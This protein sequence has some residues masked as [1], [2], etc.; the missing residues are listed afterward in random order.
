MLVFYAAYGEERLVPHQAWIE[1][2]ALLELDLRILWGGRRVRIPKRPKRG[3]TEPLVRAAL[4]SGAR[5][6]DIPGAIG[7]SRAT[8]YR[9]LNRRN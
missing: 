3:D 6:A 5:I 1:R 9:I 7:V 4:K 8:V 2:Y